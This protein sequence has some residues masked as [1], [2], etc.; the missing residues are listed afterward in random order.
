MPDTKGHQSDG[1]VR[2]SS[3]ACST[4]ERGLRRAQLI[5][6]SILIAESLNSP[7]NLATLSSPTAFPASDW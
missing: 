5:I 6:T 1:C 7:K 3:S 2:C 4:P